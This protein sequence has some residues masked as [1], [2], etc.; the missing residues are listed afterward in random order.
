MTHDLK[1]QL[2]TLPGA[3]ELICRRDGWWMAA[4]ALD[5]LAMAR[6][7]TELGA[8]LSTLTAAVLP[9]DETEVIYHYY[10]DRQTINFKVSTQGNSLPSI[11]PILPSANWAEREIQDLYRVEFKGHPQPARLIRPSQLEPGLFRNGG[12]GKKNWVCSK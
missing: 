5:V 8:R 11:S 1:A 10:F 3:T 4:P 6:R 2:Q 9:G 12:G 7:M